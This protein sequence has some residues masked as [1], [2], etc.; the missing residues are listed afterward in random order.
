M[1]LSYQHEYHFGNFADLQKHICLCEILNYL[2]KKDKP[3][4]I[5]DTHAGAGLFNLKDERALKTGEAEEGIIK[6]YNLSKDMNIPFPK[7][8]KDY[9]LLE[10]P[11]IEKNLY[12]GSPQLER[13]F[14]R[15]KDTHFVIEKHPQVIEDLKSN[16]Q[17]NL[18]VK[19]ENSVDE[20]APA[21][22]TN[23]LYKDSFEALNSLVPPLV[24]RGLILCDPSY[25]DAEDYQAVTKALIQAHKKWNTAV[26]ALWYP[27]ISRRKNETSQ[28]LSSLENAAKM[29]LNPCESFRLEMIIKDSSELTE[30]KGSHLY[31]SGMFVIN[32]P[33]T[34]KESL[35]KSSRFIEKLYKLF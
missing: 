28:M 10:A 35:E 29:N 11:Y 16:S 12:A 9:L 13:H 6:L 5:I 17:K 23:V 30:E 3:L 15:E 31:G 7:S 4:T 14:L 25:E 21:S 33:Y 32:P 2:T 20:I 24:K 34:L 26:I 8:V 27:L 18:L 1:E 22:K 19:N